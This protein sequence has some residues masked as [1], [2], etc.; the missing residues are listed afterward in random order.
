ML[1]IAQLIDKK[2]FLE[3]FWFNLCFSIDDSLILPQHFRI[4]AQFRKIELIWLISSLHCSTLITF[5]DNLKTFVLT[6]HTFSVR[7]LTTI[8]ALKL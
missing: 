8:V 1:R 2:N 4:Y 3:S 6:K 5:F 7:F